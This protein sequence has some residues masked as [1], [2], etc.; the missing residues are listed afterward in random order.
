MAKNGPYN[1][2]D[3]DNLGLFR[4]PYFDVGVCVVRE[5]RSN[6]LFVLKAFRKSGDEDDLYDQK[7]EYD[8]MRAYCTNADQHSLV[9]LFACY[10]HRVSAP[11]F[12]IR[13][14]FSIYPRQYFCFEF[15]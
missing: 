1:I 6:E 5:R 12:C 2:Q 14:K 3:F 4:C 13:I 8:F 9:H 7:A 10:Q 15:E 11:L